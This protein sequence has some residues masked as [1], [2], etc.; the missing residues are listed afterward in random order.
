MLFQ[1]KFEHYLGRE[2]PPSFPAPRG[3]TGLLRGS[4]SWVKLVL[5][6]SSVSKLFF[7]MEHLFWVQHQ[8]P[9]VPLVVSVVSHNA[10]KH[11]CYECQ[12]AATVS[13][14]PGLYASVL[15]GCCSP[16]PTDAVWNKCSLVAITVVKMCLTRSKCHASGML[17][18]ALKYSLDCNIDTIYKMYLLL[19]FFIW[20]KA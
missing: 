9:G 4:C 7:Q 20:F 16:L 15:A 13:H 12:E 8:C 17:K 3:G 1:H 14:N 5:S 11:V 10:V 18:R 19:S 2:G 6:L